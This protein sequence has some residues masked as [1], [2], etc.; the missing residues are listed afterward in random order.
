MGTNRDFITRRIAEFALEMSVRVCILQTKL[1]LDPIKPT[2]VRLL[3]TIL[4]QRQVIWGY[5]P[6]SGR[7]WPLAWLE[8]FRDQ[9]LLVGGACVCVVSKA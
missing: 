1:Y 8:G 5:R 4:K 9:R 2:G 7:L 6:E 3:I